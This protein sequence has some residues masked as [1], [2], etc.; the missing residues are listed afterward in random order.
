MHTDIAIIGMAG[1]FPLA[2]TIQEFYTHLRQGR[3]CVRPISR[4]RR[5]DTSLPSQQYMPLGF[6]EGVDRFDYAFFGISQAEAELMDPNQRLMLE[7]AYEALENA[8]YNIDTFNGSRTQVYFTGSEFAYQKLIESGNPMAVTGNSPAMTAGRI[9]RFFNLTGSAM[10]IDTTCSSS[11]VAVHVGCQEL[12]RNQADYVLVCGA[13]VVL[14]PPMAQDDIDMGIMA[15]D[16]KAKAFD[17]QANG[18]SGGEAVSCVLLKRTD[19]A[20]RDQDIIHAIIKGSA[21]NQDANRS[22]FL[23]APSKIAQTEV[24]T[25]AWKNASVHPET[26]SYIEAHGTGTKLGD[27]IEIDAL[28]EAFQT[29]TKEK[30]FCA[31]SAVKTNI[32]HTDRVAGLAGLIKATLA[33]KNKELLP[34]LHFQKPNPMIDFEHSA[35]YVQTSLKP[36]ESA[37]T[38]PR[39]AGVSA[40]GLSGTNCHVVLEEAPLPEVRNRNFPE[41]DYLFCL[42]AKSADSLQANL[43]A[44]NQWLETNPTLHPADIS[45]TLTTG[46]KHYP[47]RHAF[48]ASQVTEIQEKLQAALSETEVANGWLNKGTEK[49][50]EGILLLSADTALSDETVAQLR[51][52]QPAFAQ[53]WQQC[54]DLLTNSEKN[55]LVHSEQGYQNPEQ[56]PENLIPELKPL[57]LETQALS[58]QPTPQVALYPAVCLF[59]QQYSLFHCLAAH[60]IVS[61]QLLGIGLGECVVEVVTEEI[62]LAEGLQQATTWQPE[63]TDNLTERLRA[64]VTRESS[65]KKLIFVEL[66]PQGMLSQ[67]LQALQT[68]KDSF[69][70]H[71]LNASASGL[72]T[73]LLQALYLNGYEPDWKKMYTNLPVHRIELPV[74]QFQKTRVWGAKPAEDNPVHQWLYDLTWTAAEATSVAQPLKGQVWV[75]FMD[76]YGLGQELAKRLHTDNTVITVHFAEEFQQLGETHYCLRANSPEDFQKLEK[77]LIRSGYYVTGIIDMQAYAAYTSL[78]TT[79]SLETALQTGIYTQFHWTQAFLPYLSSKNFRLISVTSYA[80]KVVETDL[81]N[82]ARALPEVFLKALLV[83]YPMLRIHSLDVEFDSRSLPSVA[84]AIVQEISRDERLRFVAYRQQVRYVPVIRP[85]A[86]TPDP[87]A[88]LTTQLQPGGVYVVTGGASGIG[89]ETAQHIARQKDTHLL[90]LGRTELPPVEQWYQLPAD[91]SASTRIRVQNLQTLQHL[92]ATVTYHAVDVADAAQMTDLLQIIQR[93]H[94]RLRGL[95]HSA[96]V[97]GKRRPFGQ[98]TFTDFQMAFAAK[99]YGTLNLEQWSQALQPDFFLIYSSLNSVVPQR[100]TLDY[101]VANAFEDAFAVA[102]TSATQKYMAIGWPGWYE[103][104]MSLVEGVVPVI[105]KQ[106]LLRPLST[107][108]GLKALAYAF[109]LPTPNVRVAEGNLKSFAINPYFLVDETTPTFAGSSTASTR[110]EAPSTLVLDPAFTE[111]QTQLATIWWEVLKLQKISLDDD[112][113][114]IGGHSLN[115]TQVLNRIE[116]EWGVTL[117]FDLLFDY[118][119]IRTLSELIEKRLADGHKVVY[120]PIM[121]VPPQTYYEASHAQR[122]LWFMHQYRPGLTAYNMPFAFELSELNVE[123]FAQVFQTLEERHEIL[124]TTFINIDG[125]PKQCIHAPGELG[126]VLKIEDLRGLKHKEQLVRELADKEGVTSFD[127]AKDPLMRIS[128]LQLEEDRYVF[129][130][131][132]HH[133]ICDGWSLEVLVREISTLYQAYAQGYANPLQPLRIHYKDFVYWQNQAIREKDEAYWLSQLSGDLSL[134]ELPYDVAEVESISFIGDSRHTDLDA[135]TTSHLRQLAL[136]HNTSL[137]NVFLAVLN[138]VL[139]D[140]SG[141]QDILIGMAVA[142]R[143]HLDTENLIGFFVNTL[144]LRNTISPEMGFEQVLDQVSQH[145]KDAYEHQNYPFDLLVEKLNPERLSNR[146]TL[147]NVMYAFQNYVDV[148]IRVDTEQPNVFDTQIHA[149]QSKIFEQEITTAYFDLTTY[150]NDH[151][152]TL[153]I[154]FNYNSDLFESYTIEALLNQ[155]KEFLTLTTRLATAL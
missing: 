123:A 103:T 16:G 114:D 81:V 22:S 99:L 134:I 47:Y 151:G 92:G 96:G 17:S 148:A 100:Q 55:R 14:F 32:G 112:F 83:E 52:Q 126:F 34:L 19:D 4:Q 122:R 118:A 88:N 7:V 35:L 102:Q 8:G 146:Q 60:G 74:Y 9:A 136:Q 27:P 3:N 150:I 70:V 50:C 67:T 116:K 69:A 141:Q 46:R 129:L 23:T 149:F 11:L 155:Y 41:K 20:L 105:D 72:V 107:E 93:Q 91:T 28:T 111:T 127:L 5:Q 71:T 106:S 48:V 30:H 144:V 120:Q 130:F 57:H 62:S 79:E 101:A 119:T 13:G 26:I 1:R 56:E 97:A 117:E 84:D 63:P 133:I 25:A 10:L 42:S 86:V 29:Q 135:D 49:P 21:T 61:E 95:V 153:E 121:P 137:S 128:L 82:P 152:N 132:I 54:L 75:L 43:Q 115:G 110:I 77:S 154:T 78:D 15:P 85:F 64:Y 138:M 2:S 87:A 39:R 109:A 142:N 36:W 33:L 145:V 125:I 147:F 24:V 73:D 94:P 68:D 51:I 53:A 65:R 59:M 131:T 143:T 66:A 76:A 98:T 113:F 31:V 80:R 45:F 124:R 104:G 44:L 140:V 18:T 12:L 108:D 40:F 139:A 38:H 89:Y 37:S 90:I 58:T 6:L